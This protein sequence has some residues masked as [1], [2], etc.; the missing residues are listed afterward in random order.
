[1][2]KLQENKLREVRMNKGIS[3]LQLSVRTGIAPT[4]IS[5]IEHKKIHAYPGWKER[6]AKALDVPEED[7]FQDK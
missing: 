2:R 5:N 1:M 7:I 3:Q 4:V 6:L